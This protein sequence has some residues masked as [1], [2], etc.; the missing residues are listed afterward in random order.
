MKK[1]TVFLDGQDPAILID[2]SWE[3]SDLHEYTRELSKC[4]SSSNYC[5]ITID[6]QSLVFKPSKLISILVEEKKLTI[7][8]K[9]FDDD[10]TLLENDFSIIH[11]DDIIEETEESSIDNEIKEPD[12]DVIIS[13]D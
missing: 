12:E 13:E 9:E 3:Q 7:K 5:I 1:I 8:E 11:K 6:E 2:N 10:D 4:I